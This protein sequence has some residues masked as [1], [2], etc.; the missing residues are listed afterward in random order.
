[1]LLVLLRLVRKACQGQTLA[2][3]RQLP[4]TDGQS[5]ILKLFLEPI[6]SV[7]NLSFQSLFIYGQNIFIRQYQ[8]FNFIIKTETQEKNFFSPNIEMK[9]NCAGVLFEA[10]MPNLIRRHH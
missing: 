7:Q 6:R 1:M 9:Q 5:Y 10:V 8:I 3:H 2:Y 4:M